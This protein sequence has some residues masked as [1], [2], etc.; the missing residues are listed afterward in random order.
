MTTN[1]AKAK[2]RIHGNTNLNQRCFRGKRSLKIK[3]SGRDK[4]VVQPKND[5]VIQSYGKSYSNPLEDK[6][7]VSEKFSEKAKKDKKKKAPN[8]RRER[9]KE[10]ILATRGNTKPPPGQKQK[11]FSHITYFNCNKK[12]HYSKDCIEAKAKN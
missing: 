9:Q 8:D 1:W 3:D 5:A 7:E 6:T 4:Q 10:S 2:A 12:D 11:S